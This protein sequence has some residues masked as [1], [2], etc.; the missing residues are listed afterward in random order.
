MRRTI[1]ILLFFLLS[2]FFVAQTEI[3]DS[4]PK[5]VDLK[6]VCIYESADPSD[7]AFSFHKSSRLATT[8]DILARMEGVNLL[9]RGAYGLEPTIRNYSGGQTNLTIDGMRIYGACTDKMDPVSIYVEPVNLQSI[10][11]AHGASGALNG[12]T[13]GGQINFNLKEPAF[14]CDKKPHG[15]VSQSYATVNNGFN[16]SFS[17]NQSVKKFAYRVSGALRDADNYY[18]GSK[19]L[20]Q[21]SG[22]HKSNVSAAVS[23]KLD[24][25]RFIRINYLGDWGK[26]IGYPALPMDVGYAEA[27][28]VSITHHAQFKR[29]LFRFNETKIFYNKIEHQMD[30]THRSDAPMHMDMPGWSATGGFYNT[31]VTKT[32]LN[33][34]LDYHYTETRADMVMYPKGEPIMYLQTLPENSFSDIGLSLSQQL[35]FK[36]HQRLGA[37]ARFD[38]ISQLAFH[39]PGENQWK[40]FNTDITQVKNDLLKNFSLQYGKSFKEKFT[41]QLSAAYG[42]RLPTNN[43]RY[44][45]YLYNR[46]D[47]YDYMGR[48]DLKPERSFQ[49][50]LMLR[51]ASK[52][53]ECSVNLFYHQT[54][55][56]VYAYV[57]N[58]FGGMT[59]GARGLKTYVNIPYSVSRGT[60]V[61]LKYR[62]SDDLTYVNAVKYVYAETTEGT[63]L[64]LV[65]P[66]K[67]QQALRYKVKL[68]QFQLEYDYAAAQK[69]INKDFG[70]YATPDFHLLNLRVS[71]N[72]TIRSY[73]IQLGASCENIFDARYREHL[74]IGQVPRFGRNFFFHL[75]F[76]F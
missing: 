12:S 7:Q 58:G 71:R 5:Q 34:R 55:D 42:E 4:L 18:A 41:L 26:N 64:P 40:V 49:G 61:S 15:Q 51:R 66:L 32:G 23:Y 11:V 38:H 10:Q 25:L 19:L 53:L 73:I 28:I 75:S 22:Y 24:S 8:E 31:L 45:Y 33:A 43:E 46:Q 20:I 27:Q 39:G 67:I 70:D 21:N 14:S 47:Q 63:A 30:D 57:L 29:G 74:D 52:K 59:I 50:E 54:Y 60:E 72:L 69:R 9:K 16:S 65:P 1:L 76:L 37:S 2:T 62:L 56:Y 48:L 13:I 17:V 36:H 68:T 3:K 35:S 6:E 44:G